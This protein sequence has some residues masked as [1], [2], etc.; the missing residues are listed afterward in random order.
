MNSESKECEAD[1]KD[2][3]NA[4]GT[5]NTPG[6]HADSDGKCNKDSATWI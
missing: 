5:V 2:S 1:C 6:Y 4:D 3:A